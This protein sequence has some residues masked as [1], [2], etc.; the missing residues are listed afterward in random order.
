[1]PAKRISQRDAR[2]YRKRVEAL[3]QQEK[4]RNRNWV[5]DW[6]RSVLLTSTKWEAGDLVPVSIRTARKL[7]HA[8]VVTVDDGGLVK[9]HAVKL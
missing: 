6:P 4:D 8:V 5:S 7:G 3:E 2:T 1:M 9:F